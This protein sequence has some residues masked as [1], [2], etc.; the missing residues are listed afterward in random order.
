MD[1]RWYQESWISS[2]YH[3]TSWHRD[4]WWYLQDHPGTNVSAIFHGIWPW[5]INGSG[6]ITIIVLPESEISMSNMSVTWVYH[7]IHDMSSSASA[8]EFCSVW[9]CHDWC[10][11]QNFRMHCI[12]ESNC[13]RTPP[14]CSLWQRL[15]MQGQRSCECG[16]MW[17]NCGT[18]VAQCD[19]KITKWP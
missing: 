7:D 14:S 6:Q 8:L 5:C 10:P 16:T 18:V 19:T 17:Q 4:I 3:I 11:E 1:I 9:R 13:G 15:A 2:G 12:R